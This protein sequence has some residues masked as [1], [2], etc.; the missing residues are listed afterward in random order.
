[1]SCKRTSSWPEPAYRATP[2]RGERAGGLCKTHT[3]VN[4]AL[5]S[6]AEQIRAEQS[7]VAHALPWRLPLRREWREKT[8]A[9]S[10][11]HRHSC[12][13][14]HVH[15]RR[16]GLLVTYHCTHSYCHWVW[17]WDNLTIDMWSTRMALTPETVHHVFHLFYI[18]RQL[19]MVLK[20]LVVLLFFCCHIKRRKQ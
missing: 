8:S 17:S 12:T 15:N 6:G 14:T 13:H 1:M 2:S 5:P 10:R 4:V 11:G 19:T 18:W 9:G 3:S 20:Q 16:S 7:R